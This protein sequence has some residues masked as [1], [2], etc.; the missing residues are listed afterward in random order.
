MTRH[1][2]PTRSGFTLVELLV[3]IAIIAI[4]VAMLLPAV[5]A[6][7]EAARRI[8]CTNNLK[9]FGVALHSYHGAHGRFAPG[10]IS[11]PGIFGPPQWPYLI[12]H[13]F[14]YI[15]QQAI[16]DVV[17][18]TPT[19]PHPLS[20]NG[21]D[22]WPKDVQAASVSMF[23]CPSDG[24]GGGWWDADGI[25][26][27]NYANTADVYKSNYLGVFSGANMQD[28]VYAAP[29]NYTSASPSPEVVS[30][31]GPEGI[32]AVFGIN[33]GARIR[34]ISD[35]TSHTLIMVEY[36]TGT[37]L[38]PRGWFW[39]SQSGASIIFAWVTP[40]SSAP[41]KMD[42][43]WCSPQTNLPGMNLPCVPTV[44]LFERTATSRSQHPGGVNVV[45]CDG[46]VHFI[47]EGIDVHQWRAR[48]TINSGDLVQQP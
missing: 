23:L 40:N 32:Q 38:D 13:L 46:S 31:Y 43:G 37:P 25:G 7:R 39:T 5:Q 15:E 45:L 8:Q 33:R 35:G 36:L 26:P 12:V 11:N 9:Q 42:W 10:T 20:N 47:E 44:S 21:A 30:A 16:S 34:D 22:V 41:D 6:A 2:P 29:G 28:V 14:P 4:L 48:G 19:L 24:F 17:M 3:V 18:I 27:V 1:R